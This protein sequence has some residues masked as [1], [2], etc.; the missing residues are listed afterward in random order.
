MGLICNRYTRIQE[1]RLYTEKTTR[2]LCIWL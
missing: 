2:Q 1:A